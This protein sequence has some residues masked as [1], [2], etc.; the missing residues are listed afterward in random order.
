LPFPIDFDGRLYNTLT[1]PCQRVI[2]GVLALT[3]I[4]NTK[5]LPVGGLEIRG[6]E[7]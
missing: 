4:F 3:K 5:F 7:K 1:L 6:Y 2:T